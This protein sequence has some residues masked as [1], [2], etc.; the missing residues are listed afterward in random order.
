MQ[1]CAGA[2]GGTAV[3][4]ECGVC[5]GSGS[6]CSPNGDINLDGIVNILDIIMVVNMILD[7]TYDSIADLNEDGEINILDIVI[8]VNI[9]LS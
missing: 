7:I 8:M 2:W 9:I 3:E 1:D 4:D 5:D 6:P